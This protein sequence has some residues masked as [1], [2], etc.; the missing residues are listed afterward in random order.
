M[1]PHCRALIILVE[2]RLIMCDRDEPK[3]SAWNRKSI[4]LLKFFAIVVPFVEAAFIFLPPADESTFVFHNIFA[5]VPINI[6][7]IFCFAILPAKPSK[8]VLHCA[9]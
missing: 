7:P 2:S 1:S 8:P 4:W 3:A 5:L 9:F 6:H